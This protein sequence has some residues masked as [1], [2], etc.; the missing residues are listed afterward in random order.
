MML[1]RHLLLL[2]VAAL[3]APTGLA[4]MVVSVSVPP[5]NNSTLLAPGSTVAFPATAIGASTLATLTFFNPGSQDASVNAITISGLNLADFGLVNSP[6]FPVTLQRGQVQAMGLR[7]SPHQAA[8]SA[9]TMTIVLNTSTVIIPLV[10]QTANPN[11]VLT[12]TDPVTG[13]VSPL[14]DGGEVLFPATQIGNLLDVTFSAR[15]TGAG[16]GTLDSI[17]ASG[18]DFFVINRPLLPAI[19]P[20]GGVINFGIRFLPT[21]STPSPDSATLVAILGGKRYTIRLTGSVLTPPKPTASF[22]YTV[23]SSSGAVSVAPGT[24]ITAA[25]TAVSSQSSMILTV[26]NTGDGSGTINTITLQ[27]STFAVDNVP[28]LPLTLGS[29]KSQQLTITFSPR[30]PDKFTGSITIGSDSFPLA[31]TGL[32]S[33]LQLTY[34]QGTT[35]VAIPE[36]GTLAFPAVSVGS[37]TSLNIRITNTG[38]AA[39]QITGV[40]PNAPTTVYSVP[41]LPLPLTLAP[42]D[43]FSF[44]LTFAPSAATQST[45]TLSVNTTNWNLSGLG[46]P[47]PDL[48]GFHIDTDNTNVPPFTQPALR[49]SLN[50]RYS[51]PVTGTLALAMVAAPY[52]VDPAVQ[53]IT[54]GQTVSFTIP[55]GATSAVF[56][57]GRNDVDLQVGTVAGSIAVTPT[58]SLSS[59]YR[60]LNPSPELLLTVPAM[61]PQLLNAQLQSVT[62]TSFSMNV[63]GYSTTKQLGKLIFRFTP[64]AGVTL[65]ATQVQLDVSANALVYYHS[66]LSQVFG[67]LFSLTVPVVLSTD[68]TTA[69]NLLTKIQSITVTVTSDLGESAPLVIRPTLP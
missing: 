62:S 52:G 46:T 12:Y 31:G 38:T 24:A 1:A 3:S 36:N 13:N 30:T 35:S 67:G 6:L 18:A 54:G 21:S 37:N 56:P 66:P 65:A 58:F 20:P 7:F 32:G 68:Q 34:L 50:S 40:V 8:N 61:P 60:L 19:I 27:G 22:A 49:L 9:A 25:D 63:V 33:R 41:S 39:V 4:Q 55:A 51:M 14:T 59:G 11:Y 10:G 43:S 2:L 57:G 17:S 16:P 42:N 23:S 29:G 5:D 15:N 45:G 26:S 48:P 47:P 69:D 64:L 44:P 28:P 53:W